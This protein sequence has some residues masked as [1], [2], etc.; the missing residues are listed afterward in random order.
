MRPGIVHRLD[1]ETSGLLLIAKDNITHTKLAKQFQRRTIKKRYIAVVEGSIEFDE[2][3]IDLPIGRHATH[4]EKKAV[5][6]DDTAKI[7]KTFYRV[8]KRITWVTLV[9]L[10]PATG[11][12]H[13]SRVH[14]S[15]LGYPR[16]GVSKCGTSINCS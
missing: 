2:G 9:V 13:Q 3:V 6:F 14:L 4:R 16:L 8:I 12:T 15:Y 1:K 7:S 11:R 10:F 5:Q